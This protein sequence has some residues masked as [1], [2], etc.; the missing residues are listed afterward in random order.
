M[1][2]DIIG[3]GPYY[4]N[5]KN[6][7]ASYQIE[8]LVNLHGFLEKEKA[9]LIISNSL[10]GY[11]LFPN[12]KDNHSLNAEP[13][14]IK[15]YYILNKPVILSNNIDLSHKINDYGCGFI[16]EPKVDSLKNL[17]TLLSKEIDSIKQKELNISNFISKEC[18]SDNHFDKF[19]EEK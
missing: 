15:Y 1:Y 13:G 10:L 18:I 14:K 9:E 3:N 11:A 2:L 6:M 19:F 5:I 17:L 8:H 12:D 4:S 16:I 7:I